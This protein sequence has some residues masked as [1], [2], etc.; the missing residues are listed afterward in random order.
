MMMS[1]R[2]ISGALAGCLFAVA[3]VAG[4]TPANGPGAVNAAYQHVVESKTIRCGYVVYPPG[5]IR[6][7]NTNEIHGVFAEALEDAAQSIGYSIEWTE[8][9][10]WA[11][12]IE[13]LRAGRYDAICSP[14]WGNSTRSQF[15]EFTQPL[16]YSGIGVYVRADDRRFDGALASINA[17]GVTLA[18]IDGEMTSIIA[19]QDYPEARRE[20][21]PQ[22][23][24]VSQ[25]LLNVVNRRADVTFV[26]PYIAESFLANHRGALRNIAA[27][28]PV[29]IFP[30]VMMVAKGNTELAGL[31]NTMISE[32]I[33]SGN[34]DRLLAQYDVGSGTFYPVALPYRQPVRPRA[35]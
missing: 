21:L 23:T 35:Q 5:T 7:P 15:A 26:E 32:E 28:S 2:G 9:V 10:G 20:A 16:F 8:E 4:C 1:K 18:T 13:G 27:E 19:D 6:D 14:V 34:V 12:M 29:R 33:N 24:D 25:V 31:L 30:N 17:S 11:T 22:N 3:L